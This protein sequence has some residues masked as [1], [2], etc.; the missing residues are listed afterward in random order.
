MNNFIETI[1]KLFNKFKSL[2]KWVKVAII[3]VIVTFIIAVGSVTFY[4]SA[5]KYQLL[6]SGL[7][8][9]DAQM[10]TEKLK[11]QKVDMKIQ[12]DS[13]LVPKNM[14]DELRLSIAPD[15][16]SGSKG[17]ELMD[18]GSSFGMTDEEFQLKKIRMLQGELEK[19]IKSFPQISDARVHIT[20]AKDS[21]FVADSEPGK[22]AV[23]VKLASS[24]GLSNEQVESIIALVSGSTNNIPKEN[25]EVIDQNMNLLSKNISNEGSGYVS[26][27]SISSHLE[28]EKKYEGELQKT[29]TE[30]LES[31]VGKNKVKVAINADLDFDSKEKTETVVD[32]NKVIVSQQSVRE[33]NGNSTTSTSG[34]TV[35][36]NMS[37]TITDGSEEGSTSLREEQTTNYEVGKSESKIISA[38]G[39]VRRLTA[40]V[41]VDGELQANLQTALENAVANAVGLNTERGDQIS[42]VGIAFDPTMSTDNITNPFEED[43]NSNS[44]YMYLGG[45]AAVALFAAIIAFIIIRR[46]RKEKE[47]EASLLD[48]VIDDKISKMPEEMLKPIDFETNNP[49]AHIESEIKRYASEKPEQVVEIIKSWLVESER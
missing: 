33:E 13:I 48:V 9:Y 21:V 49:Q 4:S 25:I 38:P 46:R 14:V 45:G 27:E 3:G 6:F 37:N 32:P 2:G 18:S 39:E 7:D 44:L 1:K 5:N 43:T 40:S 12:G 29:V 36:E 28:L 20:A 23:Y 30:L 10:V 8:A 31:I 34:S 16:T 17:Y 22:A 15:L 24:A 47:E 11:E 42:V 41:I 35:D 19:T 26:S